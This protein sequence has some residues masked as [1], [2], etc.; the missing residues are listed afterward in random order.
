MNIFNQVFDDIKR[1]RIRLAFVYTLSI[2]EPIGIGYLYAYL[3][4]F[5][6]D[7]SI[8][9]FDPRID[10]L[11]SIR[12]YS[13]HFVL[14]S[15]MSGQYMD[16]VKRNKKLKQV[17]KPF[18]SVFGGAHPTYFPEMI[19]DEAV[20]MICRGE[21]EE[22]LKNLVEA[23]ANHSDIRNI[24]GFWINYNGSLYKNGLAP[25]N[26]NLDDLPF[27]ERDI[28]YKKSHHLRRYT[29]IS[30]Y[31]ARGC[32]FNCSYCHNGGFK[33]LLRGRGKIYRYRSPKSIVDEVVALQSARKINFIEFSADIFPGIKIDWMKEFA[34][35]Y[36]PVK[37]PFNVS[38]RAEFVKPETAKL[39]RKCGCASA[40][41]AI[42][43]GNYEYRKK[44]LYRNMTNDKL[45]ESIKILESE[46]IR[47]A[48]PTMIGLP[49]T[50][51]S[52][53]LDTLKLTCTA[54]S[55][56][57]NPTIF[58]P[59]PGVPLTDMCLEHDLIDKYYV[60]R[61]HEH[62]AS[63]AHIKGVDYDKVMR[64]RNSFTTLK[65]LKKWFDIDID[66]WF[67]KLPKSIL[68]KLIN[69]GLNYIYFNKIYSY[70]R[71]FLG[72]MRELYIAL[73][74]GAYGVTI[75]KLRMNW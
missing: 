69:T 25:L 58:Q 74:T 7:I 2:V 23:A 64:L 63:S 29:R 5:F 1:N 9:L 37:I 12:D 36:A 45:V 38:L 44:Y 50:E 22:P 4:K 67:Y 14:Y 31:P 41:M 32:T 35:R 60:K 68:I 15:T 54:N 20:D 10:S 19:N 3:K 17:L 6:P 30:I 13:P 26:D 57:A 66:V 71:G 73:I 70:K 59:Y 51:F 53:D 65:F 72:R 16:D 42:E 47:V 33:T 8:E 43:N 48:S 11:E 18:I 56:Y 21:G 52:T 62:A 75:R 46:G 34:E 24:E 40:S 49:F 61:Y 55:T 28:F 39:L 27:P